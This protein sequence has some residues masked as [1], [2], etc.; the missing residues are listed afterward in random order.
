MKLLKYLLK[1]NYDVTCLANNLLNPIEDAKIIYVPSYPNPFAVLKYIKMNNLYNFFTSFF[2]IPD[3][4]I[5]FSYRAYRYILN[6]KKKYDVVITSSPHEGTH[7]AGFLLNKKFKMSWIADFRDQW[8]DE[9]SRYKPFSKMHN[10][11]IKKIEK[12]F[13][14]NATHIVAN[15]P[16]FKTMLSEKFF[17]VPEKITAITNGYD[18]DDYLNCKKNKYSNISKHCL[19]LG[20]NGIFYKDEKLPT[21]KLIKGICSANQK[22]ANI[23]VNLYGFQPDSVAELI[24]KHNAGDFFIIHEK[25]LHKE[26]LKR[27]YRND[28]LLVCLED[29]GFTDKTVPMKLYEYLNI[30]R[31]IIGVLPKKGFAAEI[32]S[33]TNSGIIYDSNDNLGEKFY[34]LYLAWKNKGLQRII[35]EKIIEFSWESLMDEWEEVISI[36]TGAIRKSN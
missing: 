25:K 21:E 5:R 7:L 10:I 29:L 16:P 11:I 18:P 27:L 9:K 24:N 23:I 32:I 13:Y 6:N 35:N 17:I 36:S 33:K 22:G 1:R 2:Y 34:E 28:A 30:K 14:H 4:S 8:T 15:T 31:P 20:F 26:N 3:G 19:E 12:T